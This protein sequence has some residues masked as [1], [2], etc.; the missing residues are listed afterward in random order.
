MS[1]LYNDNIFEFI[2]LLFD[3]ALNQNC[4]QLFSDRP[5]GDELND[6][7]IDPLTPTEML[8]I[9]RSTSLPHFPTKVNQL[10]TNRPFLFCP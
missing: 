10:K 1:S 9:S 6:D 2:L 5:I 7:K 4:F 3:R 8:S